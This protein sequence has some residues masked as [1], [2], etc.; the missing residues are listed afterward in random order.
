[1]AD[2][3]KLSA[4][5]SLAGTWI[6]ADGD[7]HAEFTVQPSATG[8][9]VT[10]RETLHGEG[11]AISDVTWDGSVLRFWSVL[12]STGYRAGHAL[13]APPENGRLHHEVSFV[14]TWVRKASIH[15][16]VESSLPLHP[17]STTEPLVWLQHW[18]ASQCDGDWEHQFGVKI[19][20][21]DNPGW[22]L[23][24]DLAGTE[25][26][27]VPFTQQEFQLSEDFNWWVCKVE[28][29]KFKG[30]CSIENLITV[31][32]VFRSWVERCGS[33]GRDRC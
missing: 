20:T 31:I 13:R 33:S 7:S 10:G 29:G 6:E 9:I 15:P 21:L 25:L 32:G 18:Y 24:V 4:A 26:E 16:G 27:H 8:V 23:D 19:D 3:I 22:K 14:E 17:T 12:P 11:F 28:D 30:R 5:H 1:M 2:I